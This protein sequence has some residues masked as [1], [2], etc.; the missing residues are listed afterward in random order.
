MQGQEIVKNIPQ[1]G[2]E[3]AKKKLHVK[4]EQRAQAQEIWKVTYRKLYENASKT[5]T[6]YA[7]TRTNNLGTEPRNL[8]YLSGIQ[9][10]WD[11]TQVLSTELR[12]G[13]R[14]CGAE[15]TRPGEGVNITMGR[16]RRK[17]GRDRS[18]VAV[19]KA[20]GRWWEYTSKKPKVPVAG[21]T[22][23]RPC[24]TIE[25]L[26]QLFSSTVRSSASLSFLSSLPPP[27][28]HWSTTLRPAPVICKRGR[29]CVHLLSWAWLCVLLLSSAC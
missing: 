28:S 26:S 12:T 13:L 16:Y 2:V 21:P 22:T 15:P 18:T 1:I 3:K 17:G 5:E 10:R 29:L 25:R 24:W 11:E 27:P 7:L 20:G 9:N 6:I 14:Q 8:F 19:S 23:H 4:N